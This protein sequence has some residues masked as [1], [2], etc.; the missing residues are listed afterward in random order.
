MSY[1]PTNNS[2]SPLAST[3]LQGQRP[4]EEQG[5]VQGVGQLD[6]QVVQI[7]DRPDT[8]LQAEL[9]LPPDQEPPRQP[10]H[11]A[12]LVATPPDARSLARETLPSREALIDRIGAPPKKDITFLGLTL[13][14]MS[15]G[16]KDVLNKLDAYHAVLERF[17]APRNLG[18]AGDAQLEQDVNLL[19]DLREALVALENSL[20]AY[21]AGGSHTHKDTMRTLLGQVREER[22][23]MSETLDRAD[24]L[25]PGVTLGD[26]I[27]F[28][29]VHPSLSLDEVETLVQKGWN[30]QDYGAMWQMTLDPHGITENDVREAVRLDYDLATVR[31]Y[32]AARMP[33]TEGS[34][35]GA[36]MEGELTP[37]GKGAINSVSK[38]QAELSDGTRITG[39]F[40]AERPSTGALAGAGLTAGIDENRP[41]WAPRNVVTSRLDQRLGLNIIPRTEIVVHG[42]QV[43][44][45]MELA[46]GVSPQINGNFSMPLPPQVAQ[47]LRERPEVLTAYI[48]SK[49]FEGGEL[50]GD[51]LKVINEEL[52]GT[53]DEEGM[54][55]I[56]NDQIV[57]TLQGRDGMVSTNFDD[58]VLRREL[59][60]LQWLDALTGQVDRHGQ[61]YFIERT[62]DGATVAIQGI[63][64]D[65]AF[66]ARITNAN[67]T[68][69]AGF[70]E[71]I[72]EDGHRDLG[73]KGGRLPGV[74]DRGTFNA[75]M[76]LTPE[77]VQADC[78][79]LLKPDEIAATQARLAHIQQ[80]LG[81]LA[82][83]GG[84]MDRTDDWS[85]PEVTRLLG[86]GDR[87]GDR[88]ER[89]R[90]E[91][92][93]QGKS[94][95]AI[96]TEI[97]HLKTRMER[98][99]YSQGY[100]ARDWV[101]QELNRL[102]S[103]APMLDVNDFTAL[104]TP[105]QTLPTAQDA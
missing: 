100:V 82:R 89:L 23:V 58:P 21:E 48:Q 64:N 24:G 81:D 101:L 62:P 60:K 99:A 56:E 43:G 16:Y 19:A 91:L 103:M 104:L 18:E 39:V 87:P 102:D 75:L 4:L 15:I 35:A 40:K 98:E 54:P 7:V 34:R 5:Q 10:I 59:T 86:M 70:R 49:G 73:F 32:H 63:D 85:Q 50:V 94:E 30:A 96:D 55:I 90:D 47:L 83:D 36:K 65:M 84:V 12:R 44:S 51:T 67:A 37:L 31:A 26:L 76:A 6:G 72:G 97:K 29:R 1:I 79:G 25:R 41:N 11:Q 3:L 20:A 78:E 38:G 52:R 45:V 61:N 68:S 88:I 80:H 53:L 71:L 105:P 92:A 8:Q 93:G 42:G 27:S 46:K 13:H 22:A 2:P 14:K 57:Q 74:V 66:G 69:N 28:Q 95:H 33:I 17:N 77:Q 9:L